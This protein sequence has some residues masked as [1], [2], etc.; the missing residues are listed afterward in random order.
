[1]GTREIQVDDGWLGT[2][3]IQVADGYGLSDVDTDDVHQVSLIRVG[4]RAV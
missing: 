4:K 1:M 3:E 2:P